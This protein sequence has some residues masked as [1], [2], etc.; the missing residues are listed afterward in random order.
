MESAG[1]QKGNETPLLISAGQAAV[2]LGV[3]ERTL[4]AMSN[5]KKIP[6]MRI[7][8]RRLYSVQALRQWIDDKSIKVSRPS[9]HHDRPA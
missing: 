4:W 2:L 9:H 7:G 8:R 1:N 6:S 5:A 3:S